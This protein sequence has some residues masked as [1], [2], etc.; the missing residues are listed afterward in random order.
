M[1][2]KDEF[3]I[4]NVSTDRIPESERVPLL[5]EFYCR[6]VLKAEVEATE[7]KP[8][9]ASLTSHGV[10]DAQIV[11]GGLIGARVVRTKQLVIDGDDSLGLMVNRSGVVGIVAR[12]RELQL[13]PGDA[14]LTSAEDVTTYER[15][16]LGNCLSLRV[17]RR[18]LA[19]LIVDID[20]AV[21]RV[22]PGC[23]PGLRL[24]V[25]Y[26]A[27]LVRERAFS[28]PVLRQLGVTHLH[29]LMARVLGATDDSHELAGRRGVRAAR[30]RKVKSYI[31][32]HCWQ[33]DLSVATVAQEF[34][35]T[36]RYLQRLFEADGKTFSSFL[37]EQRLK[38]AHRM[39]REPDFAGRPVSSIAYDVGFGDLSYF[40]RCFRRA[41]GATPSGIRS[42]AAL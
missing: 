25:D 40:N 9:A 29:D 41:Y 30:L 35:V 7:G 34:G 24:L 37:T 21:M 18:V 36:T 8:F 31:V 20:D 33:Q 26:A 1:T 6:G 2:G 5:R 15:H 23:A 12:G 14:V 10:T 27:A 39:L 22:I 28:V 19:P 11:I 3:S 16:S 13:H 17:P 38:R 32:N 4:L 42:G